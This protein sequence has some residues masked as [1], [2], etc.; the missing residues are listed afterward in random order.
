MPTGIKFSKMLTII[1]NK[2]ISRP[3]ED[4]NNKF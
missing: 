1:L 2:I 4:Y 3:K